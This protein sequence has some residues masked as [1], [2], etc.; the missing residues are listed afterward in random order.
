MMTVQAVAET[1]S[2]SASE[3]ARIAWRREQV[4]QPTHRLDHVDAELPADAPDED[5][6]RVRVAVEILVIEMLDKLG[7]GYDPA[8]VVHEIGQQPVLVRGELDRR[9]V[10]GHPAGARIEADRAAQEFAL[11]VPDRPAQQRADTRQHLLE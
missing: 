3:L 7:A 10:D 8:G 9:A 4:A 2:R 11:G 6:D 1:N 5:L